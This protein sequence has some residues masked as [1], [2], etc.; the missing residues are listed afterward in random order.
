MMAAAAA[1]VASFP[2]PSGDWNNVSILDA[3]GAN[4]YPIASFTYL[5]VYQELNT[6][7][8]SMTQAKAQALVDFLWWC[9]HDPGG[10]QY[11]AGLVYPPLPPTVVTL[12]EQAI[13][14]I[15]FNG[16]TLHS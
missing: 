6:I 1:S 16:Q 13:R 4:S 3:A 12:D 8:T 9:V 5:L 2:T 10:Q 11:A 14:S 15:T 7:G